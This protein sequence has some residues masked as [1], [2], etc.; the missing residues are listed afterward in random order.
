MMTA[1]GLCLQTCDARVSEAR[2][3]LVANI[4]ALLVCRSS[5]RAAASMPSCSACSTTTS[6]IG[7]TCHTQLL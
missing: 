2:L 4:A 6:N 7:S 5:L 3:L 1:G